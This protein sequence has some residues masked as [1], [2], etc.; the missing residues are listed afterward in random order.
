MPPSQGGFSDVSHI[1]Q[2]HCQIKNLDEYFKFILS[3]FN[4]FGTSEISK[5]F[6]IL[7]NFKEKISNHNLDEDFNSYSNFLSNLLNYKNEN[8]SLNHDEIKNIFQ[9][10]FF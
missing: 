9:T 1:F 2:D 3:N 6:V 5:D 7:G 10:I 8:D 4:Y